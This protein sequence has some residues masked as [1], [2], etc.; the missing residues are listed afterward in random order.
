MKYLRDYTTEGMSKVFKTYGVFFAFSEEQFDDKKVNGK[1]YVRFDGG[2]L[3]PKE[4][5]EA[6]I[7]ELAEVIKKAIARDIKENSLN[8]IIKREL[9]NHAMSI[10]DTVLSLID[11]PITEADIRVEKDKQDF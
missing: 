4:N 10:D 11:Y 1:K 9:A 2:M 5:Q 8:G 6:V 3:C 7:K